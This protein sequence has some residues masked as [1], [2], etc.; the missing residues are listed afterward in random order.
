MSDKPSDRWVDPVIQCYKRDVDRTLL[1]ESLKLTPEQRI[2]CLHKMQEF[3]EELRRGMRQA[4]R[5][6]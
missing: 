4:V 2:R 1:R 3:S 5:M 6:P